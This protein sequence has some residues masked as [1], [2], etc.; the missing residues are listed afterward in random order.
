MT[1]RD[2]TSLELVSIFGH[3]E[4]DGSGGGAVEVEIPRRELDYYAS[5]LLAAGTYVLLES[6]PELV[7]AIRDKVRQ[8]ARLYG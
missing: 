2:M 5:R 6:P 7:E 4:P 3:I 1:E 8:A